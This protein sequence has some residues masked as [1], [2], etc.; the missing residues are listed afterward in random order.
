MFCVVYAPWKQTFLDNRP[1][2]SF[3]LKKEGNELGENLGVE[4]AILLEPHAHRGTDSHDIKKCLFS[5]TLSA[6]LCLM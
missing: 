3:Q 4:H 6:M 1:G 5:F 2:E